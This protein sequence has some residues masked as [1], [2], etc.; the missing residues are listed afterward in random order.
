MISLDERI[1]MTINLSQQ[2]KNNREPRTLNGE[3]KLGYEF[4][5]KG[6]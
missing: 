2:E 4:W 5:G 6:S 1:L 3:G